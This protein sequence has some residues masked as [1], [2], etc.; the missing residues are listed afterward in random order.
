MDE[1]EV[2]GTGVEALEQASR[3]EPD[4]V[5]TDVQMPDMEEIEAIRRLLQEHPEPCRGCSPC[6]RKTAPYSTRRRFG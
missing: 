5:V 1:V 3:R 6:L 4:V 2:V